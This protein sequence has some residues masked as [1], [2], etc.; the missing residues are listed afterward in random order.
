MA[1]ATASLFEP[2]S[3]SFRAQCAA[4]CDVPFVPYKPAIA[5]ISLG[6]LLGNAKESAVRVEIEPASPNVRFWAVISAT[7]NSADQVQLFPL[8]DM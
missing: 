5:E 2:D 8:S 4:P 3:Q 7:S 1:M 6:A